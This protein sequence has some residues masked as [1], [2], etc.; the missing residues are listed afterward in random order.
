MRVNRYGVGLIK[1]SLPN[2]QQTE[3]TCP[4]L[5]T[6]NDERD[7]VR[8]LQFGDAKAIESIYNMYFD[9]LYA[10][11]FNSVKRDRATTEDIVQDTFIS[12][13]RSVKGFKGK[14]KLYTWL[15]G[16][17]Y[18]KI[19]DYYRHDQQRNNH[20]VNTN[21]ELVDLQ[22]IANT[23]QAIPDSIETSETRLDVEKALSALPVDY[24]H[25]LRFKYVEGMT[26]SE[27][28]QV[29]NRSP[30]AIDGL[31]TR[32]RKMLWEYYK[33]NEEGI[34]WQQSSKSTRT[35]LRSSAGD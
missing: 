9:R 26:I 5:I 1:V 32:A 35:S 25:V 28:S 31:L 18:H 8:K 17:A 12:A 29:V 11:V 33:L 13:I 16:I 19:M 22:L 24:Q 3:K 2:R 23:R 34:P 21:V 7:L 10:F 15:V 27:I 6:N 4:G 14:S 20:H 30:K